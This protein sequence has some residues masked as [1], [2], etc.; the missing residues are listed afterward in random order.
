MPAVVTELKTRST[1]PRTRAAGC[2]AMPAPSHFSERGVRFRFAR[3]DAF[4]LEAAASK[5]ADD[6]MVLDLIEARVPIHRPFA[7]AASEPAVPFGEALLLSAVRRHRVPVVA[8]LAERGW[9]ARIPRARLSSV[10]AE[11]AGGCDPAIARMLIAAGADPMARTAATNDQ[12]DPGG[13]TALH[14]ATRTYGACWR[15]PLAPLVTALIAGLGVDVNAT[16]DAGETALF[17]VEDPDLA[18]P[19]ARRRRARRPAR[20][21]RQFAGISS[22]WSDRIVLGLLDAGAYPRG[23]YDDGHDLRRQ[24]REPATSPSV[25]A[26]LDA[27]GVPRRRQI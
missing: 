14:I 26:W 6:R 16:N 5:A 19:V 22:S 24:A 10:F 21:A 23:H 3:C 25:L 9:L 11:G 1:Q 8:L 27:H 13:A 4:A 2:V 20:Q 7:V 15:V 17:E 12:T 18:G